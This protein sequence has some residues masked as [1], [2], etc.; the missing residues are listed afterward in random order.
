MGVSVTFSDRPDEVLAA[1]GDFLGARP[2]VH[3]LIFT[4]LHARVAH[5]E[6]GRYWVVEDG[7]EVVGVVFQSPLVFHATVTPLPE[8]VV[9]EVVTACAAAG[10]DL[11]GVTGEA[12]TA[13]RFAGAWT[14]HHSSAARPVE[15]QRIYEVDRLVPPAGVTG[16]L[17][18]AEP[19]DRDL[20][21]AWI[22][23]FEADIGHSLGVDPTEAV[24]RRLPS[25]HFWLWDDDGSVS[26]CARTEAVCGVARIQAVYTPPD[27]RR[28]GYAAACV[29]ALSARVLG[30]G[31][32]CI[33][34][35]DLGNPTSNGVYRRIGYRAVVECLRYEFGS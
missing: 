30:D 31:D 15:G 4:L 23:A 22:Q 8:H 33:L 35:T 18:P 7:G 9:P 32:R 20:L 21:V 27:R 25:G 34:Y 10:A 29:A 12:G 2:V 3:N 11:P 17:R 16:R 1:A 13:A 24:D 14:E 26:L 19:T 5:P 6:P 28:R